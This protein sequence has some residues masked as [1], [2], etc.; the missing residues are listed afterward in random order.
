MTKNYGVLNKKPDHSRYGGRIYSYDFE[1][2]YRGKDNNN[3]STIAAR[4]AQDFRFDEQCRKN[5]VN[6]KYTRMFKNNKS[7]NTY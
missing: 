4:I 5:C 1:T 2:E 3:G 7:N 6:K